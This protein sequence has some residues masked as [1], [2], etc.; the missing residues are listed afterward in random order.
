MLT[1]RNWL[2]EEVARKRKAPLLEPCC[3]SSRDSD[4]ALLALSANLGG[5]GGYPAA[6]SHIDGEGWHPDAGWLLTI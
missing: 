3:R 4:G 6:S 1:N 5:D 2:S